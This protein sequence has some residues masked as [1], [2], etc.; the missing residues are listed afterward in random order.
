MII[1]HAIWPALVEN[2]GGERDCAAQWE[3]CQIGGKDEAGID[4]LL[5]LDF[6]RFPSRQ[7]SDDRADQTRD[8]A[9]KMTNI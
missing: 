4:G 9:R 1:V 3:K 6:P 2:R 5:T 7:P 8:W